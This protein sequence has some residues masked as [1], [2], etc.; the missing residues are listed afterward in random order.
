MGQ[1]SEAKGNISSN[2]TKIIIAVLVAVVVIAVAVCITVVA[3]SRNKPEGPVIGYASEATVF[4]D[5]DSLQAAVDEAQHQGM[6]ALSY[7]NN[8]YSTDGKTFSCYL[9]NSPSNIYDMFLTIFAD[10]EM[11]DQVFLSG[12]VRPG[13]GFEEIKLDRKLDPGDH[14]MY[15]ALTQVDTEEDGSQVIRGQTAYTVEFHVME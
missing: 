4:L 13:S 14:T 3:M 12:L 8:A 11:T 7:K 9:A 1:P 2:K 6:I 15:V 5:Q 10:P